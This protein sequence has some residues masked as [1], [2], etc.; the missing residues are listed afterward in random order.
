M[1]VRVRIS[2][3]QFEQYLLHDKLIKIGALWALTLC[4]F[5][6]VLLSVFLSVC[7]FVC[8]EHLISSVC[9]FICVCAPVR[10]RSI[11]TF[12]YVTW[13]RQRCSRVWLCRD[14]SFPWRRRRIEWCLRNK[15]LLAD[16]LPNP[17]SIA[18]CSRTYRYYFSYPGRGAGTSL[19]NSLVERGS[20]FSFLPFSELP[21][22]KRYRYRTKAMRDS[23]W[24]LCSRRCH[25]C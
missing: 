2:V 19:H 12:V 5:L 11:A 18:G 3:R 16:S 23:D 4:A 25:C 6:I 9:L 24:G 7:F 1:S 10:V 17:Y 21:V 15:S 13:Y 22:N 8:F 14:G 20:Y